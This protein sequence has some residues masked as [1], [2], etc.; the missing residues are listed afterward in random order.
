ML[1]E[2]S[3]PLVVG[4]VVVAMGCYWSAAQQRWCSPFRAESEDAAGDSETSGGR[5]GAACAALVSPRER[6]ETAADA[7]TVS[8]KGARARVRWREPV[9]A[10][11]SP[12]ALLRNIPLWIREE[13]YWQSGD[14]AAIRDKQRRLIKLVLRQARDAPNGSAPAPIPGE[15]RRG[16][17]I[18]CE[19]GTNSGRAARVRSARRAVV[20]AQRDGYSP[21]QLGDLAAELSAFLR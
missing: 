18:C 15:S 1:N 8:R 6:H 10:G 20:E 3:A 11:S 21:R 12:I 14:Y 9:L 13:M 19:P 5:G 17:G 4:L 7:S 2:T 16:L